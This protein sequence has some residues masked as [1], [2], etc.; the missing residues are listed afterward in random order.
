MLMMTI[1]QKMVDG[2]K[3]GRGIFHILEAFN[4]VSRLL[5]QCRQIHNFGRCV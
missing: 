2:S 3:I 4:L 1:P 5:G